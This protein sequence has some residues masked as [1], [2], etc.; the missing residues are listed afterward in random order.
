MLLAGRPVREVGGHPRL[1]QVVG[2]T[3]RLG[4]RDRALVIRESEMSQHG[5]DRLLVTIWAAQLL[6]DDL[7]G[8]QPELVI[9]LAP[10]SLA[11]G[12]QGLQGGDELVVVARRARG[13][14]AARPSR[15]GPGQS[16]IVAS[17]VRRR[18]GRDFPGFAALP[19]RKVVACTGRQAAGM[20]HKPR[21]RARNAA[22]PR[23]GHPLPRPRT[24][25]AD[26]EMPDF[27]RRGGWKPGRSDGYDGRVYGY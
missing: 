13:G 25:R 17:M 12:D 9:Q 20:C 4:G 16:W 1:V 23:S 27:V 10:A 26:Y 22:A 2:L 6:V 24:T 8:R 18:T 21:Q 3:A 11:L 7:L 5:P 15:E 14:R 19:L